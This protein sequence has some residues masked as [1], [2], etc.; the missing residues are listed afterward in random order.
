M[1]FLGYM[2]IVYIVL[3]DL[4]FMSFLNRKKKLG[5]F[6]LLIIAIITAVLVYKWFTS[7]M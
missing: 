3:A 2:L 4:T 1:G 7:P 5:F 6:F